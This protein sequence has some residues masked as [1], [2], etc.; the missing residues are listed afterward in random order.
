M[1][2]S[3]RALAPVPPERIQQLAATSYRRIIELQ[4]PSGAYPASP[5]FSA[6][7]GYSW[8]RD[9]AFIADGISAYG[10]VD[11]ANAFFD[12]CARVVNDRADQIRTIVAAERAGTPVPPESMLATR[13]TFDGAEGTDEWWDFQ[14][15]GYGTWL[16]AVV[17]HA[18]RHGQDLQRWA[19]AIRS[20]A[21]YLAASWYRPC[22]DW[23]EE[24]QEAVHGS[25]LGCIVGG[26]RAA[27]A[28][29]LLD[30]DGVERAERAIGQILE[31]IAANGMT[32]D[33]AIAKWLGSDA[34]DASAASLIGLMGV[35]A[36]ESSEAKATLGRI[37][38]D[39]DVDGGV[40]RFLGDTFY[41][42]GQWPLL[43]CFLG[44]AELATGDRTA[45]QRHLEF[46][47]STVN[48]FG[49]MPEQVDWHLLDAS[50]QQ[51]WID[52]W[53]PVAQ[54]LLWSHAMF[55]RL[56]VA[57]DAVIPVTAATAAS[58]TTATAE[59]QA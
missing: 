31:R 8:F 49:D 26:L 9:G 40:H 36:P 2:P 45:A 19:E 11:S 52:R 17:E 44:L 23:W 59:E 58:S 41:G 56:A 1:S 24:H 21:D 25:T 7:R 39:L 12:W 10:G 51:E 5:T 13:F 47:A 34:V 16:W 42:G 3:A 54:P 33:G 14:L 35:Y 32:S 48:E 4:D 37:Q 22:F 46:A 20:T 18:R 53:G 43:S 27:I 55:L 15:D 57:L 30:S 29:G 38:R 50:F 6:Y 28:S